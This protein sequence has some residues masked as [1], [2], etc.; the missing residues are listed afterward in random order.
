M[1]HSY[2]KRSYSRRLKR[3]KR[4]SWNRRKRTRTPM[5]RR[6]GITGTITRTV[7]SLLKRRFGSEPKYTFA[8]L[9]ATTV[10]ANSFVT[11][12]F[13]APTQLGEKLA[14]RSG[15]KV[16]MRSLIV[17]LRIRNFITAIATAVPM[18]VNYNLTG[19]VCIFRLNNTFQALTSGGAGTLVVPVPADIWA[20][21]SDTAS[22]SKNWFRRTDRNIKGWFTILKTFNFNVPPAPSP[23]GLLTTSVATQ[24]T[25]RDKYYKIKIRMNRMMEFAQDEQV[26]GGAVQGSLT[27]T[28]SSPLNGIYYIMMH[29]DNAG[30]Y[31]WN[32]RHYFNDFQ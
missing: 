10:S 28:D 1:V 5:Y 24:N 23:G 11:S 6:K 8:D 14:Q 27:Y 15:S 20:I 18:G 26:A 16:T 9:P 3:G 30:T 21:T 22:Q 17:N 31:A 25:I 32:M 4:S 19:K 13:P 2:K 7:T 29:F 12:Q